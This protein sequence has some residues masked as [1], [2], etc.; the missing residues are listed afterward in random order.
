MEDDRILR[1]STEERILAAAVACF[2]RSGFDGATMADIAREAT[3]SKALVHYHF[4]TKDQLLLEVQSRAFRDLAAG[5]AALAESGA[6]SVE[7]GLTGL[8]RVW[9]LLVAFRGQ[10][11]FSLEM[12]SQAGRRPELRERLERF[13]AEMLALIEAG[14][15]QT[16][17]PAIARLPFPPPRLARVLLA[18]LSGLGTH[19][20]FAPLDSAH[21]TYRDLRALLERAL[22]E[23]R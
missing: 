22:K 15:R 2:G 17:G 11:P 18:I 16:L 5:I 6:P 20:Y 13:T 8:D 9:D 14:A 23:D 19:A 7:R 4:Q 10:I 1:G 21:E 3:V 12:W